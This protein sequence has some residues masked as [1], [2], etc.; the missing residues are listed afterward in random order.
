MQYIDDPLCPAEESGSLTM[1]W[2]ISLKLDDTIS[3]QFLFPW[4]TMLYPILHDSSE[5]VPLFQLSTDASYYH[6]AWYCE[7]CGSI[8]RR[9][10]LNEWYCTSPTCDVSLHHETFKRVSPE[11]DIFNS[12][13]TLRGSQ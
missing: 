11:A 4:W 2:T 12:F 8:N 6:G 1:I 10:R 3:S 5:Y 13:T 9:V 7:K